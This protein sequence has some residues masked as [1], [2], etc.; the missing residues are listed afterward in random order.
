MGDKTGR[1]HVGRQDLGELQTRKMKG[2]KRGRDE[3]KEELN[4]PSDIEMED[5]VE[6]DISSVSEADAPAK[7]PR[8]ADAA[9]VAL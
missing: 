8:T 5:I 6:D 2:L 1:V 4:S 3:E 9:A 7:R